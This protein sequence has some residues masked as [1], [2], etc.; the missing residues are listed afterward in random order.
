MTLAVCTEAALLLA[1][2]A[3]G[4]AAGTTN[5]DLIAGSMQ[6]ACLQPPAALA[7]AGAALAVLAVVQHDA[8]MPEA[9]GFS[10]SGLALL[11]M[12]EAC[13]CCCG[14]ICSARCSCRSAWCRRRISP[15]AG[16][17]AC[18][19]GGRLAVAWAC[20]P[21]CASAFGRLAWRRVPAV[22]AVSLLLAF[23]ASLLVLSRARPV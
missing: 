11:R 15:P 20:W 2:L 4:L 10:A 14:S 3:L 8:G 18:R 23:L 22:L 1:V 12:A 16:W 21:G 19:L 7:L 17:L 5:V 9:A 6:P 13:G